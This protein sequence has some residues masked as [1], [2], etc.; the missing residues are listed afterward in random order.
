MKYYIAYGSNLNVEQMKWRCPGAVI[1]GTAILKGWRLVFKGS[2]TG[3]Y[4]TI[5]ESAGDEVPVGI[6]GITGSD[7]A[8]LDRY[9][10]YPTFYWKRMIPLFE[11]DWTFSDGEPGTTTLFP[12]VYVMRDG[13]PYGIPSD[14]Y[15]QVCRE[16]YRDFGFESQRPLEIAYEKSYK[17]SKFKVV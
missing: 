4:L 13:A 7:E 16:G 10:G 15:M 5:E 3:S 2:K 8:A 6:W 11:G 1:V 17:L 14:Y 12:I 9:E